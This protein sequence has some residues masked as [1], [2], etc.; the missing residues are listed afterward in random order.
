MVENFGVGECA[1]RY[2]KLGSADGGEEDLTEL[3]KRPKAAVDEVTI[4]TFVR[5]K[6]EP[7]LN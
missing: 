3:N 4:Q 6:D 5:S 2:G 7:A 1:R